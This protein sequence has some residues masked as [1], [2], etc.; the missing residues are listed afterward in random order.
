MAHAQR[1]TL[2]PHMTARMHIEVLMQS[3][4]FWF[5]HSKPTSNPEMESVQGRKDKRTE[6]GYICTRVP[7]LITVNCGWMPIG[8]SSC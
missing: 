4:L 7:G 3:G 2:P 8:L 5:S 1:L 6:G